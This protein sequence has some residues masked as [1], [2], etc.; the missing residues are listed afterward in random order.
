[1]APGVLPDGRM[2]QSPYIYNYIFVIIL[3]ELLQRQGGT[4][5]IEFAVEG[6]VEVHTD[7]NVII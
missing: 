3:R 5:R 6:T 4:V 2:L 7:K 1:M